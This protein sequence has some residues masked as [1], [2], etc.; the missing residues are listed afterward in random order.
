MKINRVD[1]FF[2]FLEN[3]DEDVRKTCTDTRSPLDN[4]LI[5]NLQG[6]DLFCLSKTILATNFPLRR[7]F[8]NIQ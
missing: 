7:D 6:L 8:L 1:N 4:P 5:I 3:G 2:K